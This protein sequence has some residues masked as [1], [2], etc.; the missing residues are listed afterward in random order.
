MLVAGPTILLLLAAGRGGRPP[1]ETVG[2]R[3]LTLILAGA[4]GSM[5]ALAVNY[6]VI[7][8]GLNPQGLLG[9]LAMLTCFALFIAGLT[10]VSPGARRPTVALFTMITAIWSGQALYSEAV[11][12][13]TSTGGPTWT[14][15]LLSPLFL[16]ALPALVGLIALRLPVPRRRA[17]GL[18][19]DGSR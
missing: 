17:T 2:R 11:G 18:T 9:F 4:L 3:G 8:T 19:R 5:P 6:L 1:A 10:R 12:L 7:G 16:V 14:V 15:A 13:H